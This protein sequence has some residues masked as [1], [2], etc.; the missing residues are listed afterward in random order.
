MPPLGWDAV[1]ASPVRADAV[2]SITITRCRDN[3]ARTLSSHR[4]RLTY[5]GEC[6]NATVR[7]AMKIDA[8]EKQLLESVEGG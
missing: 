6:S 2:P 1:R 3:P 8:D 5:L 7:S 4:A